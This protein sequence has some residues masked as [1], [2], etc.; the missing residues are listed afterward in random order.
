VIPFDRIPGLPPLFRAF[1]RGEA[2]EFFPDEPTLEAVAARSRQIA[3]RENRPVSI[4]A[5]QQAGLLGG[6]LL[7]L[8]K[9]L[10]ADR[11]A[12]L[13]RERGVPARGLFW[14]ASEDHDLAEISSARWPSSDGIESIDLDADGARTFRPAGDTPLPE[15]VREIWSR[16][17][18]EAAGPSEVLA[19]FERFWAPGT[20]YRRA[21]RET[22]G[23]L[24]QERSLDIVDPLDAE[25]RERKIDFF[26]R[27][28]DRAAE[29]T[30]ALRDIEA[31]L[32]RAGFEPQVTRAKE[33][34][35]CFV[36][37]NGVRR[38]ISWNANRF[39]VYGH[40]ES[41]SAS[42]LSEFA[43]RP[44]HEPSPAALLRPVLQAELFPV[45]AQ[46]LGPSE[47]S[48]HAQAAVLFGLF[49][50]PRPVF[51]PRPQLFPRGARERRAQEALRIDDADLLRVEEVSRASAT[52][53]SAR[54]RALE[55]EIAARI[56]AFAT[57]V[58]A[59]DPTLRP[60]L[61]AAAEKAAHPVARLREKVERAAE[62][63]DQERARRVQALSD[64][65]CP[66]GSPADRVFTPLTFLLRFGPDFLQRLAPE[67]ECSVEGARLV[68]FE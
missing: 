9:A 57:D 63:R 44:G 55:E 23:Y 62:R 12:G 40:T 47:L 61:D 39:S 18:P 26:R 5:G 7:S 59:L 15:K 66:G 14:I 28:V 17:S 46:I 20:S 2:G 45:A 32:R 48:Y 10:A 52:P 35:P 24:L 64:W 42:E 41:F 25:W 68:D 21:F 34:F 53:L 3:L 33:D 27:A 67:A 6:P 54:F 56:A 36:I 22:L 38:K 49:D 31:K 4:A 51:L 8:T 16:I 43:S 1:V 30:A 29:L 19:V 11:L 37:E 65:F 60:V 58:E 50:L 13:L